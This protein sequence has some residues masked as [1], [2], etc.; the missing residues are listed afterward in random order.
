MIVC[1]YQRYFL[2]LCTQAFLSFSQ[3]LKGDATLRPLLKCYAFE[4]YW[5]KNVWLNSLSAVVWEITGLECPTSLLAVTVFLECIPFVAFLKLLPMPQTGLFREFLKWGRLIS[6]LK[7][8]I[9]LT[10]F[11]YAWRSTVMPFP[12]G[13]NRGEKGQIQCAHSAT[14]CALKRPIRLPLNGPLELLLLH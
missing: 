2:T 14:R 11:N 3:T 10:Y 4:C 12:P 1:V 8:N 7:H 5:R 9:L 13:P 6:Y